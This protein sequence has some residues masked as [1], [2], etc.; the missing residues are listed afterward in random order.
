MPKKQPFQTPP[1]VKANPDVDHSENKKRG[2]PGWV[3]GR[4]RGVMSAAH[5]E[6]ISKSSVL[7]RLISHAEGKLSPAGRGGE[8]EMSPSQ[9]TAALSLLDRYLPKVTQVQVDADVVVED[10][11]EAI[12]I[13]SV[14]PN[15]PKLL[16]SV[17]K[18]NDS[19]DS[20][21]SE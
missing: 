3:K 14:A 16:D 12:K 19:S 15:A 17:S 2:K 6:K 13:I 10:K 18:G 9:V 20:V 21:E 1:R 11:L 4:K 8:Q 5:R 7:T